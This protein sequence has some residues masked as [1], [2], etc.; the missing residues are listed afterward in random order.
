MNVFRRITPT[1]RRF[2]RLLPPPQGGGQYVAI[3]TDTVHEDRDRISGSVKRDRKETAHPPATV[4][5]GNRQSGVGLT[6]GGR[7][8]R[9]PPP[10]S[11]RLTG[12]GFLA[13]TQA[14]HY[15]PAA[16]QPPLSSASH[17]ASTPVSL[18]SMGCRLAKTPA[19]PDPDGRGD[20]RRSYHPESFYAGIYQTGKQATGLMPSFRQQLYWEKI[21]YYCD[22]PVINFY[23]NR[24]F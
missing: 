8:R 18:F 11:P 4:S 14:N 16:P 23:A 22:I 3:A 15:H 17:P 20:S 24:A 5:M 9:L 7:R 2:Q 1:A 6:G 19:T 13:A 12:N 21:F 10:L